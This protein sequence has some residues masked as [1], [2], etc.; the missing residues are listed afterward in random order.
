MFHRIYLASNNTLENSTGQTL[1]NL[2]ALGR[3]SRVKSHSASAALSKLVILF[4][5]KQI[6]EIPIQVFKNGHN[7]IVGFSRLS[8]K[9]YSL[10][11]H[12]IVVPPKIISVEK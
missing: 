2:N 9:L 1:K 7:A 10:R 11:D 6:P 8:H 12:L 5:F 4:Q 3:P